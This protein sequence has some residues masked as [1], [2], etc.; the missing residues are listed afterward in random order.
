MKKEL[1]A[2]EKKSVY[3]ICAIIIIVTIA[4]CIGIILSADFSSGTD[5][6]LQSNS[7]E[8]VDQEVIQDLD[9]PAFYKDYK[10]NE[11]V[12]NDQY[13]YNRYRVTAEISG[14]ETGGLLNLTGG[15]TLTMTTKVDNTV[16]VFLA[17]FEKDQEE[18]L[19]TINVGD[20]I[21]FEGKC[22]GAGNWSECELLVK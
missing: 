6:T 16:V 10:A 18:A 9:F 5:S 14:M 11:L 15:A 13:R 20:T 2:A 17:E 4:L 7:K 21:T 3:I 8:V 19:K 12:A 1:T 22:L